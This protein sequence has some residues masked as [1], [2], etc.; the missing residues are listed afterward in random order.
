MD[1]TLRALVDL[2]DRQIQKA[3]IQFGNRLDALERGADNGNEKQHELVDRWYRRFDDLETE[4]DR[5]IIQLVKD[6]P[7]YPYLIELRG[8]GPLLA[9][10]LLALIDIE[11]ASHVSS[12]WKYAGYGVTDG[13]RD[14]PKKGEV[15]PYNKRLKVTCHLIATSF[16]KCNSPYRAIY[17]DSR[18]YYAAN[19]PDWTP[20][21]Q[22]HAALRRMTKRFLSHLWIVWREVEGLPVSDPYVQAYLGHTHIDSPQDYGWPNE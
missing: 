13:E 21:H 8:I 4:L 19:R 5:D 10:K 9:A 14:R 12:L 2:R 11:R 18:Q 1:S 7:A 3:R 22:H 15:L 20:L 17:D 6:H 16:L